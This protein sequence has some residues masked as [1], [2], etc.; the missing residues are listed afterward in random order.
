MEGGFGRYRG[1]LVRRP[2]TPGL[3]SSSRAT[4]D[5]SG[6]PLFRQ[7]AANIRMKTS[8]CD[9]ST[10]KPPETSGEHSKRGSEVPLSPRSLYSQKTR[11]SLRQYFAAFNL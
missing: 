8:E 4:S 1:A 5:R 3:I 11:V 2:L 6:L 7:P 9:Q 10:W